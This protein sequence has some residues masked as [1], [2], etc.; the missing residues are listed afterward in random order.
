MKLEILKEQNI[1]LNLV[2]LQN[3]ILKLFFRYHSTFSKQRRYEKI[4]HNVT[5]VN[6]L[7]FV[8]N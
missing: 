8:F 7:F 4:K 2:G 3:N 1:F 6:I 5:K